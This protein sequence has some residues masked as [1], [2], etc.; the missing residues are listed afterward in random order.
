VSSAFAVFED[1]NEELAH[2]GDRLGSAIQF[3]PVKVQSEYVNLA[4][5]Q[6]EERERE[7]V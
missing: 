2:G 6:A 4:Y 5:P 7:K 1:V 3:S